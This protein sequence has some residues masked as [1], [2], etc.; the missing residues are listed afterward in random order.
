MDE[1]LKPHSSQWSTSLGFCGAQALGCLCVEAG[2]DHLEMSKQKEK[3]NQIHLLKNEGVGCLWAE[4]AAGH[5][6]SHTASMCPMQLPQAVPRAGSALGD[7]PG[8][9]SA[10]SAGALCGISPIMIMLSPQLPLELKL[11]SNWSG[12]AV[13]GQL[14]GKEKPLFST[15]WIF[16]DLVQANSQG[17]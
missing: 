12:W 9:S 3:K 8:F 5:G 10:V 4:K 11:A 6:C 16:G 14:V 15:L 17:L 7:S 2:A 13:M 1:L